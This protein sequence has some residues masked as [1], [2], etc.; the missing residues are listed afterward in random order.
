MVFF[1]Q[2]YTKLQSRNSKW[3]HVGHVNVVN[4]LIK[5]GA[6]V[7]AVNKFDTSV[8]ESAVVDDRLAVAKVLLENGAIVNRM[9]T[10]W[11]TAL[12]WAAIYG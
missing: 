6:D 5:S 7:N 1:Q 11:N 2:N 10:K 8:L 4:T 9:K 3:L 12:N